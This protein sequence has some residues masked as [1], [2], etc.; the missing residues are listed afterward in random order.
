MMRIK[1]R[2]ALITALVMTSSAFANTTYTYKGSN[3][4]GSTDHVEIQFQTAQPLPASTS[5]LSATAAGVLANTGKLIVTGANGIVPGFTLPLTN[6]F[7]HTNA[8]GQ[9][10]SWHILGDI[11]P[12]SSGTTL[13]GTHWQAY[14]MN[15]RAYVIPGSGVT[16]TYDYDQGT[17]TTFYST[18]TGAPT[19]CTLAGNGQPY[20]GE[21]SGIINPSNSGIASWL[22]T[23]GTPTTP[24]PAPLSVGVTFKNGTVGVA[25][26]SAITIKGGTAPYNIQATNLP[27]GLSVVNQAISGKPSKAGTYNVSL[28]VTDAKGNLAQKTGNITIVAA[29]K[30]TPTNLSCT[31]SASRA[32]VEGRGKVTAVQGSIVSVNN[33]ALNIASCSKT[34]PSTYL[35]KVGDTV[36]WQGVRY[37][38]GSTVISLLQRD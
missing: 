31:P 21:Y 38:N 2:I 15:S 12:T 25:Y 33:I 20:V 27:T 3:F 4:F 34:L 9:I 10:D 6:F 11:S 5:Y 1:T 16:G 13:S 28:R 32:E 18:C 14:S 29:P 7:I 30:P 22:V 37:S 26:Q 17:R 24:T 23:N 35:P 36:E 19:G 8:Q